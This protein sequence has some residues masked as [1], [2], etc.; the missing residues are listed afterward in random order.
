MIIIATKN[1]GIAK[2]YVI[3]H[4]KQKVSLIITFPVWP[5]NQS[6]SEGLETVP[7]HTVKSC[8]ESYYRQFSTNIKLKSKNCKQFC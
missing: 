3:K 1:Q 4:Y 5:Q 2:T 6:I 8:T 7:N